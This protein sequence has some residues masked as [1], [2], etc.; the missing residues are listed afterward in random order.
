[1][2]RLTGAREPHSDISP[3]SVWMGDGSK[4]QWSQRCSRLELL[5]AFSLNIFACL[6]PLWSHPS[7]G[8]G[9]RYLGT[10]AR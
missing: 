1:M 8:A 10:V 3:V 4:V 7:L 9:P 6:S 2:P 5:G